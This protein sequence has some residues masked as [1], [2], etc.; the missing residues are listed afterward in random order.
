MSFRTPDEAVALANNSRYGLAASVWSENINLALD[1]APRVKA[2]IVWINSTNQFDAAC[3]F[4]GYKESGFGREGGKE[5]MAAYLR[6]TW[7]TKLK[8]LPAA[9]KPASPKLFETDGIDRT[10]KLYV[11]GKQSRPDGGYARAITG[12]D[13]KLIAEVG[14]GNRKD[15]RNAVEAARSALGWGNKTAHLR[16]QIL[17]Y[18]GENLDYRKLSLRPYSRNDRRK[19]GRCKKKKLINPLSA[20]LPSLAGPI[21]MMVQFI[22]HQHAQ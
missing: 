20:Y 6:P 7:E 8:S 13:G 16:S 19:R 15:I 1:I 14:E 18:M 5:G 12:P 10:A 9:P 4:G 17:Y 22:T 21:N 11:G 2:G 3:G